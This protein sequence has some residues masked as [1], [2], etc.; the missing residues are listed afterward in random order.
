M[1][2]TF[3]IIT[4]GNCDARIEE[5]VSSIAAEQIPHYEVLVVGPSKLANTEHLEVI[6]W[7]EFEYLPTNPKLGWITKKKNIIAQEAEYDH[8]VF[9]H[10]YFI[11]QP[12]W[13]T[14]WTK[15]FIDNEFDVATNY[16]FTPEG[17]R[18]SDWVLSPYDI[19]ELYP[20]SNGN[21]N[22]LLPP[23]LSHLTRFMYISGGYWVSTR[24]FARK[25]PQLEQYGWG[26]SEDV[27]WSQQVRKHTKFQF[28]P[29]SSVKLMKNGKWQP[30]CVTNDQISILTNLDKWITKN[31]L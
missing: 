31:E 7:P 19:W 12:G 20:E 29:H 25:Y 21:W 23:D 8:I 17:G 11:L 4:D 30:G 5:I 1:D 6:Y 27:Y 3:G 9:M 16:I 10:D 26:E 24:E 28:N 13:Y 15:F 18:H 2:F 14:G 22:M